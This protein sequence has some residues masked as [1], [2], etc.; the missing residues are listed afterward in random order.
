MARPYSGMR[1]RTIVASQ[2]SRSRENALGDIMKGFSRGFSST[3]DPTGVAGTS[4]DGFINTDLIEKELE[5]VFGANPE[6]LELLRRL[7]K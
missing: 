6:L 5:G 4:V 7:G 3:Y 1:R 2:P